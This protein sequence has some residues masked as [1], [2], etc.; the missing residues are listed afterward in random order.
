[1]NKIRIKYFLDFIPL[2]II[3]ISLV[4]TFC[5]AASSDTEIV[6]QH[7]L[8]V[9]FILLTI[10]AFIKNHQLGVISLG[11]TLVLGITTLIS[12]NVGIE[13]NY[14]FITA[15]RI[16]IF[17]GNALSLGWLVLHFILSFRYYIGIATKNYWLNFFRQ[18]NA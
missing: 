9:I 8:G 13:I 1:M 6:W 17:Y 15:A 4:I 18:I 11:L 7:Y 14:V 10:V 12:F 5:T 3:S 16:P 2:L